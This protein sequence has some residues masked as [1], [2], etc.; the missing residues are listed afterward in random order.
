MAR[1]RDAGGSPLSDEFIS[2]EIAYLDPE[3]NRNVQAH[4]SSDL[5]R[6]SD[7]RNGAFWTRLFIL[8]TL[9]LMGTVLVYL[10]QLAGHFT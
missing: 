3:F 6:T 9:L 7:D 1:G 8:L 2:T 5:T 4:V 10:E